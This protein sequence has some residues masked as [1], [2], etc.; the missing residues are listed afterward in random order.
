MLEGVKGAIVV[1]PITEYE[2]LESIQKLMKG[3]GHLL[4]TGDKKLAVCAQS[5]SSQLELLERHKR[6][7]LP[8][9]RKMTTIVAL[10]SVHPLLDG[11]KEV[12][13]PFTPEKGVLG[14]RGL[15]AAFSRKIPGGSI[16]IAYMGR[17]PFLKGG[18]Q[19]LKRDHSKWGPDII[20]A[21]ANQLMTAMTIEEI[22][23]WYTSAYPALAEIWH[24]EQQ[25]S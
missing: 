7:L 3:E 25:P 18:S 17:L 1:Y 23:H 2:H 19:E 15:N 10:K 16:T 21:S 22:N 8:P 12:Y 24:L 14:L 11:D 20:S 5:A 6:S 9:M 4:T 13:E